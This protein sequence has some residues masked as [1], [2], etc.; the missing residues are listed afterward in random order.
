[1]ARPSLYVFSERVMCKI[2]RHQTGTHSL[3]EMVTQ[4]GGWPPADILEARQPVQVKAGL[5]RKRVLWAS[6]DPEVPYTA[7]TGAD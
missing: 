6:C 4:R 7:S 1:M 2:T 5:M 3:F